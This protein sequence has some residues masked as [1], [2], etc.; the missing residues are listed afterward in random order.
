VPEAR[1]RHPRLRLLGAGL[2][3]Y[4]VLGLI[5]FVAV[6]VAVNR[7]LERAQAL[8]AS[9]ESERAALVLT[10][11]QAQATLNGMS[12]GVGRMDTSLADAKVATDRASGIAGDMATSMYGL[13]DAMSLSIFGAQPLIGLASGF[14]T[15]G[16]QLQALGTDLATI[17]TSLDTNRNDAITTSANLAQLATSVGQ[18]TALVSDTQGVE[19]STAS[20]DAVRLAVYAICGWLA[21]LALGCIVVG[22]YLIRFGGLRRMREVETVD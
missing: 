2:A 13:R 7:P 15:S 8:S 18:M 22:L 20:L 5:L 16:Q 21:V 9:V 12:Q 19:I 10:L 3:V 1:R 6:A 17:G 4:G 11:G 14:D